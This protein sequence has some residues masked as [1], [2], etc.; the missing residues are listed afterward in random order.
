M[1]HL[2]ALELIK[3]NISN[4][5]IKTTEANLQN[6]SQAMHILNALIEMEHKALREAEQAIAEE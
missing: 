6:V 5:E 4:L 1:T 3:S 2:E